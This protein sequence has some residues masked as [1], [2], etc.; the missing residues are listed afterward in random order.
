M[1]SFR[2]CS[3]CFGV[4]VY[5]YMGFSTGQRYQCQEC[6]EIMVI[7]IEF[8]STEDY[9]AFL[10][11]QSPKKFVEMEAVLRKEDSDGENETN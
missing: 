4:Q 11:V 10:K 7:P 2:I 6:D 8:E 1:A 5:P 3:K 9:L